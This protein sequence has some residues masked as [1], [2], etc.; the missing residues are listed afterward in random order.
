M[1]TIRDVGCNL[2]IATARRK[3]SERINTA[4]RWWI[5]ELSCLIPQRLRQVFSGPQVLILPTTDRVTVQLR[6]A[7]AKKVLLEGSRDN[8]ED[9]RARISKTIR[10][11]RGAWRVPSVS[12]VV[13]ADQYL[14]KQ[15]ALPLAART[16]LA[17]VLRYQ[18]SRISPFQSSDVE[19][20]IRIASEQ[21]ES[22]TLLADV[23]IVP[24][25]SI[26]TLLVVATGLE[27]T[28]DRII[29]ANEGFGAGNEFVLPT[30]RQVS[31]RGGVRLDH[32]LMALVACLGLA[33]LVL[34]H[35]NALSQGDA[36]E[37]EIRKLKPLAEK[38]AQVTR[39]IESEGVLAVKVADAKAKAPQQIAVLDKLAEVLEDDVRLTEYRATG[40]T[41]V[42]AG[43]AAN[44]TRLL[45]ILERSGKFQ[46]AKF[47]APVMRDPS[48]DLDRFS[49]TF[50]IWIGSSE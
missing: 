44:A 2:G 22:A 50:E 9:L 33:G 17:D 24:K 41:V 12:I 7:R 27:L 48:N 13:P 31:A 20:A 15:I 21:A 35:T 6:H 23:A 45:S 39:Q 40:A 11:R 37:A 49:I 43:Y 14:R 19:C 18:L 1:A 42:I 10:E 26:E 16:H 47:V 30:T 34:S 32:C 4:F 3:A 36:L 8:L 28:V 46:G 25:I 5:G 29:L 38:T